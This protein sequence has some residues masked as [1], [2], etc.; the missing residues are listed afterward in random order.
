MEN[1]LKDGMHYKNP[2]TNIVY[3]EKEGINRV[4]V[5]N[6]DTNKFKRDAK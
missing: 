1:I 6:T 4:G 5:F 2:N 3:K